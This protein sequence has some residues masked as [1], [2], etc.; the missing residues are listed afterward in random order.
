MAGLCVDE[1]RAGRRGS[2]PRLQ[3]ED[4]ARWSKGKTTLPE[5]EVIQKL[6]QAFLH[7]RYRSC[8]GLLI[9]GRQPL[10]LGGLLHG[11]LPEL[12]HTGQHAFPGNV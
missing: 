4:P 11:R 10:L 8:H 2:H 3:I 6:T 9:C 12:L 1:S 7:Q 5:E